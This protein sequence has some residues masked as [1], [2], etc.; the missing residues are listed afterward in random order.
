MESTSHPI[1]K[2]CKYINAISW[3]TWNIEYQHGNTSKKN[4]DHRCTTLFSRMIKLAHK[5]PLFIN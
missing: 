1:V 4:L 2:E 3:K 5:N